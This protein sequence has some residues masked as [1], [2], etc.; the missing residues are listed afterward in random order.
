MTSTITGIALDSQQSWTMLT[1][2]LGKTGSQKPSFLD[3]FSSALPIDLP[4]DL[5]LD[6]PPPVNSN[7]FD[8]YYHEDSIPPSFFVYSP[9]TPTASSLSE[10][11]VIGATAR[12][13]KSFN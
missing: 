7:V 4:I 2:S 13:K 10:R 5:F 6:L 12:L 8:D 11:Y 1:T 9:L 3:G